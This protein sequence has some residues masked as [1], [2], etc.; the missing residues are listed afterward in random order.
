MV[1]RKCRS[2]LKVSKKKALFSFFTNKY[3]QLLDADINATI[4]I[5][6]AS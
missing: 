3:E 1:T 5:T 6:S 2:Q 4:F